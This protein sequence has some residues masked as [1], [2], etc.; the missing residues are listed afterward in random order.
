MDPKA[1]DNAQEST[2]SE[3]DACKGVVEVKLDFDF[4]NNRGGLRFK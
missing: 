4:V 1:E 3:I 2:A